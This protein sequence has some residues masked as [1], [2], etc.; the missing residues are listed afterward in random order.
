MEQITGCE[1]KELYIVGGG[2]NV[3]ILNQLTANLAGIT[4]YAGPSEATAIGNLSVQMITDGSIQDVVHARELVR[5]S[6]DIKVYQPE[7]MAG[8]WALQQYNELIKN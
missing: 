5:S 2:S 8:T 6:F 3:S 7:V 1:I 4:V